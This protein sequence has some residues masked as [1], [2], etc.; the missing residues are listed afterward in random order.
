MELLLHV[1]IFFTYNPSLG[2]VVAVFDR[3]KEKSRLEG[4]MK[5]GS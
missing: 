4:S 5:G 3:E 2:L 1:N